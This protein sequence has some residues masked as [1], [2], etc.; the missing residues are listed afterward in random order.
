MDF[1]PVLIA[2]EDGPQEAMAE[3]FQLK[4]NGGELAVFIE[5]GCYSCF[6]SHYASGA[7]LAKLPARFHSYNRK[8]RRSRAQA[9]L[10]HLCGVVGVENVVDTLMRAK[11]INP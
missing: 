11:T 1:K 8:T 2:T 9:T 6:L 4:F 10:D 5:E 3:V 7:A